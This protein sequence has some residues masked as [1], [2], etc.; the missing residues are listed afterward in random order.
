MDVEI[1]EKLHLGPWPFE[2]LS[3]NLSLC[4]NFET[5][6]KVPSLNSHSSAPE[7][8]SDLDPF[9]TANVCPDFDFGH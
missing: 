1:F 9:S 8:A 5:K 6:S 4:P 3:Q 2:K 7:G